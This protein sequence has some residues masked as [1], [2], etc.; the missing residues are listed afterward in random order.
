M[1]ATLIPNATSTPN[2]ST[3]LGSRIISSPGAL[4]LG[5][6]IGLGL[7]KTKAAPYAAGILILADLMQIVK[8]KNG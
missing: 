7:S 3:N 4:I 8:W 5:A 1:T 6:A 2:A